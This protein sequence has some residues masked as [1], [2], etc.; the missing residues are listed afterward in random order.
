M[1]E[2]H[3]FIHVY[4]SHSFNSLRWEGKSVP[5]FP[6][7]WKQKS[8]CKDHL[9]RGE[10]KPGSK[11]TRLS[12]TTG[13]AVASLPTNARRC[14]FD[15]WVGKIPWSR[16]R[17]PTPSFLP[18]KSRGFPDG[19][20]S[21]ESQESDAAAHKHTHPHP[22]DFK[23]QESHFVTQRGCLRSRVNQSPHHLDCI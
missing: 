11:N 9:D 16:K 8:L 13:G 10:E 7:Y 17:Q 20:Q 4:V 18:G 12:L 6:S 15:P 1:F 19:L 22:P 2:N 21:V 3:C 5:G 23:A 14:R